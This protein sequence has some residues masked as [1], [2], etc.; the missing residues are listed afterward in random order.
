MADKLV[1]ELSLEPEIS[2]AGKRK[3]ET[4]STKAGENAG[5]KFEKGFEKKTLNLGNVLRKSFSGL[6]GI[7]AGIGLA[8][9]LTEGIRLAGIQ[10]DAVNRLNTAL[11]VSGDFTKQQS[12]ELQVFASELQKVT[13]FGDE[14][15]L[16]QLALAKSFG[17]TNEQAKQVVAAAADLAGAL[18]IDLESATRNVAKTLGGYAGEL[19][20]VIP[21][22]KALTKEQLQ[23]GAGIDALS[24]QFAGTAA[25]RAKTFSGQVDQLGNAF[26]DTLE[27]LGFFITKNE[28]LLG[29]LQGGVSVL[30]DF[31][32]GLRVIRKEI[33]GIGEVESNEPIDKV[34][35]SLSETARQINVLIDRKNAYEKG[36]FGIV[37][38][39]D[40][41]QAEKLANK[42]DFLRNKRKGLLKERADIIAQNKAL[43]D[44][45][46]ADDEELTSKKITRQQFIAQAA[47]QTSGTIVETAVGRYAALQT[48]REQD[49]ISETEYQQLQLEIKQQ[50]DEQLAAIDRARRDRA[51]ETSGDIAQATINSFKDIKVS[52]VQLG[53]DLRNLAIR[54]F[55]KSFQ[56][57]G[58]ALAKGENANQAFIESAKQTASEAASAFGDY[59][60]K[61][62]VARIANGDPNGGAVLAG[63]LGLKVLAGALGASGGGASGGGGGGATAFNDQTPA[64]TDTTALQEQD[65][66]RQEP[67]TNVQVV[68]EGSLIRQEE[69]GEYIAT[70]L[71]DSFGKQGVALTDARIA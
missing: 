40:R 4:E 66:E 23:A 52:T 39:S 21:A 56:A 28:T 38:E 30:Q 45:E 12:L 60:I 33:L 48:L 67:S 2:K 49:V 18:G 25:Q 62:G 14:V 32:G 70:T 29:L 27:E 50:T 43:S 7:V 71:S 57:I 15:I 16:N 9:T 47:V 36:T 10:E 35:K 44:K 46:D 8:R 11:K 42:I 54:G 37:F 17:A 53:T 58:A 65:V 22:L 61:L 19:G 1:I 69:L 26:G 41:M 3:I 31:G 55:G 64:L 20:E 5:K 68:V 24:K 63:G 34:N 59:Y 6:A 13:R 51:V